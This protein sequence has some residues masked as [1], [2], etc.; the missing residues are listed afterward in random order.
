MP[1]QVDDGRWRGAAP[2]HRGARRHACG[3][4]P[5][6]RRSG[7]TRTGACPAMEFAD[8]PALDVDVV[9]FATGVRPRDELARE[10]GLEVGERGGVVVDDACRTGGPERLRRSARCACIEGRCLGP[11]RR[12]ATRWPRSS[13]TGC[14]AATA[15]FPGADLSTK[16]K[17]LGVDVASFG[18][19]FAQ[20]ARRPRGR[21]T[22]TRWPAS[23]RSSCCPT[24]RRTLLGGVLVGDASAYA[25]L[26]PMVGPRAR[27][28]PGGLPAARRA[29]RRRRRGD[30]PDDAGVC[31]CNN[32]T[33]G[34]DPRARSPSERLHRPRR[35]Q[36]VHEGRHQLRLL[37]AAGQEAGHHRAGEVR[38]RGQQR[39]VRALR[40]SRRA[41][42][43]R[44]RP[45]AAG[46]A[47]SARSSRAHGA[48]RG[49]D[50]CKPGRRARSWP[51]SAPGHVLDGERARA[52][53]HQRPRDGQ[54]AEGRHLLRRA[55]ASPAA[56]SP[57]RGCIAIGQVAKDFGLYTK[58]TGGQ[59]I[60]LFGARI[61]QLPAIWQRLVDAGFESGHA[62]GK[63]LRTVKS[64]VGSTW[65]RYGVQDSVGLADRP[66]AAL[67]RAA[68]AA[69][70]QARRLRLRPR[71][72][73]GA[74][75]GRRRHR[76]RQ[77]LEPLRRRQRRLHARGTP[78][79]S[80]RTSTPRRWCATIDRF[81]M[82]YVRTADR[83]QRTAPGSR[84]LEGGL[85]AIRAVVLDDRLG[86]ARRPR[87]GDGRGTSTAT[88]TSGRRRSTTRRSC[89]RF[90]SFVNAPET[91]RPDAGL[92]RRARPGATRPR[93]RSARRRGPH[94]RPDPGGAHMT[95]ELTPDAVALHSAWEEVCRLLDLPRARCRGPGR[96]GEQVA[97]FRT[98]DDTVFA[99]PAAR[100]LQRGQRDVAR[101][102]RQPR[103][104]RATVASPDV[105]AGLRPAHRP[106]PRRRGPPAP[107]RGRLPRPGPRGRG[108]RGP[109]AA[110]RTPCLMTALVGLELA[111]R[112]VLVAGG[113]P[114]RRAP[115]R[116][117]WW[118]RVRW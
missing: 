115:G 100:P 102:R 60:D 107:G 24:T 71:V 113:G 5:R 79:C 96:T 89:A 13:P 59:R 27:R 62:Y 11:G 101:D 15:T 45:G 78:S 30:L 40:R 57:P 41:A 43:V 37:P 81:L 31:S 90:V 18:D 70:D 6:H 112:A 72:R 33:A 12:R 109:R 95:I 63:S 35:R 20:D 77:R 108:L 23:T 54:P 8:G 3:P 29:A 36:G 83:L 75:Q 88:R 42:A 85:D 1:L 68:L 67:P 86:I 61:E 47:R 84:T 46:C 9:V 87:R 16:L 92:R 49:C 118:R 55:R 51:R 7:R 17:L 21:R 25:S 104:E 98:H 116:S 94:R 97:L 93:P 50:I 105:Q 110:S 73:R 10:A 52:A 53:G 56:R 14:S 82:Y 111:G 4:A 114:C 38:R 74:R 58:I 28:R 99:R 39:A 26:R 65:C 76:H 32:V 69:Q 44:R 48:G 117:P 91:A 64:C 2:A 19:A 103:R 66:R 22:P 34:R 106:V 80:P